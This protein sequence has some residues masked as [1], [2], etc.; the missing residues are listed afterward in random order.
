MNEHLKSEYLAFLDNF[1]LEPRT[2]PPD[3]EEIMREMA[4]RMYEEAKARGDPLAEE[5]RP[6]LFEKN[7]ERYLAETRHPATMAIT[8]ASEAVEKNI[9]NIPSF[10]QKFANNVFAGE[11]PTGSVNCEVLKVEAGYI[12]LVNSGMITVLQQVAQLLW[13]GDPDRPSDV[14]VNAQTI[15]GVIEVLSAYLRYGNPYYGPKPVSGG[16]KRLGVLFM[17]EA[18]MNFVIAHEY[19]HVLAG[20]FSE[21]PPPSHELKTSAGAIEVIKKQWQQELEADEIAYRLTLG[22][23]SYAEVDLSIIDRAEGVNDARILFEAVKLKCAIAAPFVFLTIAAIIEE[24]GA[25]RS[26]QS[27]HDYFANLTHPPAK[28]RMAR[29]VPFIPGGKSRY[30]GF[31]SFPG[32]LMDSF[33]RIRDGIV[34]QLKSV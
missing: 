19:G 20:H 23:Q 14:E 2:L 29:L 24:V 22:V 3:R 5:F 9:Q 1:G 16:L 6:E 27:R 30:F 18:C 11:F 4:R 25:A 8:K 32:I 10:R 31:I 28:E 34:D 7:K 15:A 26:G 21:Q 12:V 13:M 17:T 33:D